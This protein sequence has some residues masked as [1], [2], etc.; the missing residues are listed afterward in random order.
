[1]AR[2]ST[3]PGGDPGVPGAGQRAE[4]GR[5]GAIETLGPGGFEDVGLL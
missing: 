5:W 2:D 3:G 1:M 4:G